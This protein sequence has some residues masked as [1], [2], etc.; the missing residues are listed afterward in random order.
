MKKKIDK[1]CPKIQIISTTPNPKTFSLTFPTKIFC[2]PME[3]TQENFYSKMWRKK[4]IDL[5]RPKILIS[6]QRCCPQKNILISVIIFGQKVLPRDVALKKM[7]LVLTIIGL[8]KMGELRRILIGFGGAC[9]RYFPNLG[10]V[11]HDIF[12][13]WGSFCI[14]IPKFQCNTE[15]GRSSI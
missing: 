13:I 6:V 15:M 1:F 5:F 9:G 7:H 4:K 3:N 12:Q 14:F 2:Q 8:S 10:E 11:V